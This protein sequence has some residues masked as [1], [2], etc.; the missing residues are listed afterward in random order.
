[1]RTCGI[2][3]KTCNLRDGMDARIRAACRHHRRILLKDLLDG[4]FNDPLNGGNER[5]YLP[6][7]IPSPIVLYDEPDLMFM[8]SWKQRAAIRYI[9][10]FR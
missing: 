4:A 10:R 9:P 7:M 8:T 5:L 6:A 1:M 3:A 2:N